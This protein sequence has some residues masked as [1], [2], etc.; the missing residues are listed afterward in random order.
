MKKTIVLIM[1]T[2]I[3]LFICSPAFC[4]QKTFGGS[5]DDEGYSV[6]QTS[7]GGYI[8]TGY[9]ASYGAGD[10]DVYLIKTDSNGDCIWAQTFGGSGNDR[11]YSVQQTSDGG[12]IITGATNSFGTIAP[13][14]LIKTDASGD[15]VWTQAQTFEFGGSNSKYITGYSVRQTSD[16]GYAI[17]GT[18]IN[19]NSWVK[20]FL[21]K[22]DADGNSVW[23]QTYGY[24]T[25]RGYS[26]QLTNDGGYIITGS[27]NS[28]GFGV[29]EYNHVVLIKTDANGNQQS[30]THFGGNND[31]AGYSVQQT[32]D[33]GYI[34]T[35]YTASFGAGGNDVYLIK[36]DASGN[37]VWTQT[38]GGSGDDE[39]R[40]V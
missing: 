35:G 18:A 16:G 37:S 9:T 25:D 23:S 29:P 17:A 36:A 5:G 31:D 38:F 11:G 3:I 20:E 12:Y 27:T 10:M 4:W 13:V 6:Q 40:S 26:M 30:Y 33:G 15:C 32:G 22:T 21:I 2:G 7:D 8:I 28:L 14:Y 34:V 1:V 19:N 24:A 39:G